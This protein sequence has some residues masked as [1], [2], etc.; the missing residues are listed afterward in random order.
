MVDTQL[1]GRGIRDS[2]VLD[3]MAEIPRE[4]FLPQAV[5][6]LAYEDRA[7]AIGLDQTI[8]QPYIVAFMT[9]QLE[10]APD[11]R[12]LE[13]GTG[14]GYQAAILARLCRHVFTIERIAALQASASAV[15]TELGITNISY[16]VGDGSLGW[17]EQAPFDRIIV[18]AAA[19]A[20]PIRLVD[21]LTPTGRMILPV[22]PGQDQCIARVYREGSRIVEVP[23]LACRFVKLIGEDAWT[24]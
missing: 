18:T 5:R 12:V 4:R 15:L 22:G 21:Q 19:P 6:D 23:L 14:S 11:H 13:V 16:R 1:R 2:R 7:V 10:L 3:A 24:N 17:P 8:S 20:I 9:E